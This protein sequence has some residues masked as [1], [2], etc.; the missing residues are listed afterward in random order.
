MPDMERIIDQ[1]RIDMADLGYKAK[2]KSA[3]YWEGYRGGK[4][5]ARWEVAVVFA[6][7]Y[8]GIAAIGYF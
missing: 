1:L 4:N 3:D 8:F 2:G 6:A 5:R 7:I